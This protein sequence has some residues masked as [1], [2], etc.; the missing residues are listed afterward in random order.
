MALAFRVFGGQMR[1]F[2]THLAICAL[3]A[4]SAAAEQVT[5]KARQQLFAKQTAIL[6]GR[7][8]QQYANSIRLQPNEIRVPGTPGSV[9]KFAGAYRGQYLQAAKNA[10]QF[11]QPFSI[12]AFSAVIRAAS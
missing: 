5:S 8:A 12:S 2:L 1:R 9:P 4:G 10:P 3:A 6:D 7:A 11:S